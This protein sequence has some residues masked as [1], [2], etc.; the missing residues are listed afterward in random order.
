MTPS[1]LLRSVALGTF[2]VVFGFLLAAATSFALDGGSQDGSAQAPSSAS[3]LGVVEARPNLST[4]VP[5]AIAISPEPAPS[6][7]TSTSTSSTST[8]IPAPATTSTS[9]PTPA[10]TTSTSTSTS[11]VA[12]PKPIGQQAEEILN[13]PWREKFPE[14]TLIWADARSG[15][16]ALTF[17]AEKRIEMYVRPGD[18]P[19]FLARVLAHEFGHVADIELNDDADRARWREARGISES[20]YW[21]PQ[22]ESYDFDTVAG[23]FAE[24]FATM[25][26][27]S[28]TKSRVAGQ[29]TAAQLQLMAELVG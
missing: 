27:G 4:T 2:A 14:W 11:T 5:E 28:E 21:W 12:P 10:A 3:V 19:V 20:V 29:P 25:L 26:V 6:T 1:K 22:G 13:Y 8:S 23:D 16:R 9:I 24:A 7:S 15:V 18:D 17:P